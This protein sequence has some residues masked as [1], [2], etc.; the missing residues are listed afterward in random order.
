MT[1][2]KMLYEIAKSC[3]DDEHKARCFA[4]RAKEHKTVEAVKKLYDEWKLNEKTKEY[5][6]M[7]IIGYTETK[8]RVYIKNH[9]K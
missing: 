4:Y 3:I 8:K 7:E 2:F 9:S 6:R 5:F 1:K